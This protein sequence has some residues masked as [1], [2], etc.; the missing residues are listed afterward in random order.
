MPMFGSL[1]SVL[2]RPISITLGRRAFL[3]TLAALSGTNL[4]GS[5]AFAADN[6]GP[7]PSMLKSLREKGVNFLNP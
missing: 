4:F 7:D 6:V 2:S 1:Q 5:F 3:G